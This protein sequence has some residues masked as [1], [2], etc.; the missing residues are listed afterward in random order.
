MWDVVMWDVGCGK[1]YTEPVEVLQSCKVEKLQSCKINVGC[2][3]LVT[4]HWSL[5]ADS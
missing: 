2:W 4:G 3:S 1:A 5:T